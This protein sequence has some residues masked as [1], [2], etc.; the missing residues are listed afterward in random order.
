MTYYLFTFAGRNTEPINQEIL[1]ARIGQSI[2]SSGVEPY[3]IFSYVSQVGLRADYIA[4]HNAWADIPA[5]EKNEFQ[6]R[7]PMLYLAIEFATGRGAITENAVL[8]EVHGKV[9]END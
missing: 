5:D 1:A 6:Q 2:I 7:Y 9:D 3:F 8:D 4:L